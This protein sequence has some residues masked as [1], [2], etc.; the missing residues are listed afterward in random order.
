MTEQLFNVNGAWL[1]LEQTQKARGMAK[2]EVKEEPKVVEEVVIEEVEEVPADVEVVDEV[3]I[4]E[5][6]APVEEKTEEEPA[7]A[8]VTILEESTVDELK[9]MCT[10]KG[11]EFHHASGIPKLKELLQLN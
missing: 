6:E 2:K 3:V 10:E 8:N 4:E 5:V 11:I 7:E 9:A 1:N